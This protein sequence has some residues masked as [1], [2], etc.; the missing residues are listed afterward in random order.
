MPTR[1]SFFDT[2]ARSQIGLDFDKCFSQIANVEGTSAK[3][4]SISLVSRGSSGTY[5]SEAADRSSVVES[6]SCNAIEIQG[7]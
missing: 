4:F 2:A 6:V 1:N 7:R 3:L 5:D